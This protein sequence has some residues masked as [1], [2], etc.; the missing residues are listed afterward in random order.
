MKLTRKLIFGFLAI[1]VFSAIVGFVGF[2]S[3]RLVDGSFSSMAEQTVPM[4]I[5][6]KEMKIAALDVFM[7]TIE[8]A[9]MPTVAANTGHAG[10]EGSLREKSKAEFESI[11]DEYGMVAD[12]EGLEEISLKE[13]IRQKWLVFAG[14]SD[15]MA[16]LKRSGASQEE[17]MDVDEEF[18]EAKAELTGAID[19]GLKHELMEVEGKEDVIDATISR[20]L[21]AV[22]II[23][24]TSII[25]A[26]ISGVIF[27]HSIA[28]PVM[29]LARM[30]ENV[31]KRYSSVRR[32]KSSSDDEIG[33]LANTFN[34]MVDDV[35]KRDEEISEKNKELERSKKELEEKVAELERFNKIAVGRE[36]KMIELK[37]KIKDLE[38]NG[39]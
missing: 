32:L 13:N 11:M 16:A 38:G 10:G 25:S 27:A 2:A 12:R 6:L 8:F 7:S 5:S 20:S 19:A 35:K 23:I 36:L 18:E 3:M 4:L 29:E 34:S 37:K 1:S 26:A 24:V 30:S 14:I 33:A 31:G 22:L 28:D 39:K 17:I 9:L 15:R 21:F